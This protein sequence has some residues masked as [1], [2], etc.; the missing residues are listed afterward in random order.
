MKLCTY[1]QRK[2]TLDRLGLVLGNLVVD[3]VPYCKRFQTELKAKLKS[4]PSTV[5]D[6]FR[7]KEGF[8]ILR[9]VSDHANEI[10]TKKG[11]DPVVLSR[12]DQVI[13]RSPVP[14]P[15]LI[16]TAGSNYTTILAQ[17][18]KKVEDLLEP[19]ILL[20]AGRIAIGPGEAILLPP[21]PHAQINY[22]GEL[23][24]II[25]QRAR[26]VKKEEAYEYIAGYT[27]VNDVLCYN[28]FHRDRGTVSFAKSFDTFAP[29]GP[30]LVTRDEIPDPHFLDL[31]L[32]VNGVVKQQ[33][34]TRDMVFKVPDLIE[35]ISRYMTM[36]PGDVI[37]T[38]TPVR[39]S[40]I[41]SGD[42][43]EITIEKVGVLR[44]PV[45]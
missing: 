32:K 8:D 40:A 22:E 34:N 13:L 15:G 3:V 27:V 33:G 44:N 25:S 9:R 10:Q 29:I 41:N 11:P 4:I 12:I 2:E 21:D 43:V 14:S 45:K 26:N 24:V 20:K 5:I 39:S 17:L 42:M 6:V 37:F 19:P 23:G 16:F 36:E 31:S 38:G 1:R 30:Y 35:F 28:M 18:G 7:S